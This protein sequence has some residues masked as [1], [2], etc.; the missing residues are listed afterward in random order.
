[1]RVSRM[2]RELE[3]QLATACW[4]RHR[5]HK[6]VAD[7]IAA[8]DSEAVIGD[9]SLFKCFYKILGNLRNLSPAPLRRGF[10]FGPRAVS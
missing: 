5:D 3:L 1:M 4:G 2:A 10:S 8:V 9:N 7:I 6:S